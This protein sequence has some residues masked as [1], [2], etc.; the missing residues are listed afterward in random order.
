MMTGELWNFDIWF[1]DSDKIYE[2]IH[3]CDMIAAKATEKQKKIIVEIKKALI[4]RDL[5]SFEKYR[6]VDVY[7]A[8]TE[9]NITN[10]DE[11]FSKYD[12]NKNRD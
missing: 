3:Y 10:I 4:E 7:R 1:F 5:Y 8:V 11:F 2:T 6:S 9:M 12:I